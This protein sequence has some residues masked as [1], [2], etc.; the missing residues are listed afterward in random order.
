[1]QQFI[2]FEDEWD[3][4]ENLG[5]G[6]LVPYQVGLLDRPGAVAQRTDP[7]SPSMF[8]SSLISTPMRRAVPADSSN[9]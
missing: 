2:P 8:S 5:P 3:A 4:L 9:T 6:G 1:M 7:M